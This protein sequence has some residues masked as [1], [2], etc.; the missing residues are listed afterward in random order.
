MKKRRKPSYKT[1]EITTGFKIWSQIATE[2]KL[3]NEHLGKRVWVAGEFSTKERILKAI[4]KKGEKS[5]PEG[6]YEVYEPERGITRCYPLRKCRLH[7][8]ELK[9]KRIK[10]T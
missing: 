10:L 5:W 9:R 4:H 8:K 3:K 2:Q 1:K 7:P 6:G